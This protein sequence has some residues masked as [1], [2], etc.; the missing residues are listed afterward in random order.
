MTP[1][2]DQPV[3]ILYAD[4]DNEDRMLAEEALAETGLAVD[5]RFASDGEDLLDYLLRRGA[6]RKLAGEPLPGLILL[7]L[8]MPKTDGRE[9]LRQIMAD[10]QLRR[11]PVVVWSTSD[12]EDDVRYC[13]GLGVRGF[14]TKP[15]RFHQLV[16]AIRTVVLYWLEVVTPPC[17]DEGVPAPAAMARQ[18]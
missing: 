11:I 4:D 16:E 8:N 15:A 5:M 10:P 1:R 12:A 13:Y 18:P 9:A 3:V 14:V 6:Y 17:E 7:D 2:Q